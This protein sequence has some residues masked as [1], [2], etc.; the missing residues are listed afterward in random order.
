MLVRHREDEQPVVGLIHD[1]GKICKLVDGYAKLS[2][3][4]KTDGL[5][6]LERARGGIHERSRFASEVCGEDR[7][8]LGIDGQ[9]GRVDADIDSDGGAGIRIEGRDYVSAGG[10]CIEHSVVRRSGDHRGIKHN[11]SRWGSHGASRRNGAQNRSGGTNIDASQRAL[12][13]FSAYELQLGDDGQSLIAG[14]A[15]GIDGNRGRQ[16]EAADADSGARESGNRRAAKSS[17]KLS[18][19]TVFE[20][21][22]G[23]DSS[24]G[25]I[26][27]SHSGGVGSGCHRRDSERFGKQI[28]DGS[29][30]I[31]I[32]GDHSQTERLADGNALRCSADCNGA[33][34]NDLAKVGDFAPV[35][36][37]TATV[38][39]ISTTEILLLPLLV[40]T[41]MGEN[42][43][44]TS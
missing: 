13:C 22:I 2:R 18:S 12:W 36:P 9:S 20:P 28:D 8:G 32:V 14:A 24:A 37:P 25:G 40:T 21:G 34:G 19:V 35:T 16:L 42:G 26:V 17:P 43:P 30:A 6:R 15:I 23:D 4:W 38:G 44:F 1:D 41:A 27:D 39:L 10:A 3:A 29:S 33:A 31:T 11:T 5:N 7:A